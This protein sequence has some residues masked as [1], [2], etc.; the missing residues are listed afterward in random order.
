MS[1]GI[2]PII[3]AVL[4]MAVTLSVISIFSSWAPNLV[5]DVT[6]ETT[7]S[8]L[9][10][11]SCEKAQVSIQSAYYDSGSSE[12]TVAVRNTGTKALP[13]VSVASFDS[14]D[15]NTAQKTGLNLSRG[16]LNSTVMTGINNKPSYIKA[17]SSTCT[18]IEDRLDDISQ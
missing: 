9:H 11:I 17:F 6:D 1:K 3:A 8:T 4:L 15:Q 7:N 10:T 14:N 2:S 12:V 5:K 18:S 13:D 16:E